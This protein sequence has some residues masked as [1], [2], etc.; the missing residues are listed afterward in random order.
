VL[1]STQQEIV[2]RKT[3]EDLPRVAGET[4]SMSILPIGS[5]AEKTKKKA[6]HV[7]WLNA[8]WTFIAISSHSQY[9]AV[10]QPYH[11]GAQLNVFICVLFNDAV[12]R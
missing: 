1:L 11:N 4:G 7:S 8:Q 10:H 9:A 3:S 12:S 5:E 6:V 2:K